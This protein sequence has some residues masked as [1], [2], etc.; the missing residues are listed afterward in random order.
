MILDSKS[1]TSNKEMNKTEDENNLN[2]KKSEIENIF[3]ITNNKVEKNKIINKITNNDSDDDSE[4]DSD[5]NNINNDIEDNNFN[6]DWDDNKY[7]N[8]FCMSN[9]YIEIKTQA[10][11]RKCTTIVTGLNLDKEKEKQF[12]TKIK[13]T[14]V[15]GNKKSVDIEELSSGSYHR[16]KSK[17]GQPKL[18]NIKKV[19]IFI[20]TGDC[21][22]KIQEIL[23]NDFSIDEES[24]KC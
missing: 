4:E 2:I 19:E 3:K 17:K 13:K 20:F 24:I 12:L 18:K 7:E 9:E 15:T 21:K 8:N 1:S 14:G 6:T 11:G 23:V 22:D 16:D 10:R 5:D